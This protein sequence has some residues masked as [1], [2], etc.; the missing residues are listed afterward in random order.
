MAKDDRPENQTPPQGPK[1]R[2]RPPVLDLKATEIG[3]EQ[4]RDETNRAHGEA[5]QDSAGFTPIDWRGLTKQPLLVGVMSALIGAT[6]VFAVMSLL[7]SRDGGAARSPELASEIAALTARIEALGNRPAPAVSN[8]I[9]DRI[10]GLTNAIGEAEKRLAAIER[11]PAPTADLSGLNQRNAEIEAALKDLRASVGELRRTVERA[12]APATSAGIDALGNRIGA[13]E[14][15]IAA[16]ATQRSAPASALAGD[17]VALNAL[18]AALR[19]GRPFVQEL[20]AVRARLGK[21]AAP[22][23]ALGQS[24]ANGVPTTA[25]LAQQFEAIAPALLRE[26]DAEGGILSR[27]LNNAARLVEVRRVGESEGNS[28]EAVIA[29]TEAKLD[30]GDLAGALA[31]VEALPPAKKVA[32]AGWIQAAQE[33]RDAEMIVQQSLDAV[34]ADGAKS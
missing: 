31:E 29:R 10:D 8:V 16:L 30:R 24:A 34:L 32:A 23:S 11:R 26:P 2:R 3:A 20:E 4:A 15:R 28:A 33:R 12:P 17:I 19:S 9:A 18:A 25:A 22:L 5:R 6:L 7:P 14:Q 27:L 21:R 1:R 13:M